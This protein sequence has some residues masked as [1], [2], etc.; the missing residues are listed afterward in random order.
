MVAGEVLL[1]ADTLSNTVYALDRRTGEERWR[2]AGERGLAGLAEGPVVAGGV[3]YTAAGDGSVYALEAGS[4]RV[5]WHHRVA[6][7]VRGLALCGGVLFVH[8]H[9]VAWL[10]PADGRPL[11]SLMNGGQGIATS[12]FT[13]AGERLVFAG[14]GGVY[15]LDCQG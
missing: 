1:L 12:A 14:P 3:V 11:G 5:L 15:A 8:Y 2:F 6:A 10:D 9:L 13:V 4:G 7:A